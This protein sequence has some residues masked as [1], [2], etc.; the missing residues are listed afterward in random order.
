MKVEVL[1]DKGQEFHEISVDVA[2]NRCDYLDN[3]DRCSRPR[4]RNFKRFTTVTELPICIGPSVGCGVYIDERTS[5]KLEIVKKGKIIAILNGSPEIISNFVNEIAE[6][7]KTELNCY[8][9]GEDTESVEIFYI[10]DKIGR[11]NAIGTICL[12]LPHESK[13]TTQRFFSE[14]QADDYQ[15]D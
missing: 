6:D 9:C 13:I 14:R 3:F 11:G 4:N 12:R 5:N 15:L 1:T 10:G 8:P 2:K 7:T